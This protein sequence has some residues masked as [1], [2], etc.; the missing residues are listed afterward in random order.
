MAV[1]PRNYWAHVAL[2]FAA[3][4]TSINT[5]G[6][7]RAAKGVQSLGMNTTFSLEQVYQLGQLSLY[8]NIENFPDVEVT[9]EKVADGT[10]L[11]Q[12]LSTPAAIASSLAGRFNDNRSMMAVAFYPMTNDSASGIPLVYTQLSGMYVSAINWNM[13]LEGNVTESVTWVCRDKLNL[14]VTNV[15]PWASGTAGTGAAGRLPGYFTGSESPLTAS[16]GVQRRENIVMGSG[17][18]RWP[19]DIPG[20]DANGFN[21]SGANGFAAHIQNVTVSVNLGR[22]DLLELGRRGP[23]FRYANFPIEVSTSIDYVA[24]E[25]GDDKDV[26]ADQDNLVDH[27]IVIWLTDGTKIDLGSRNKLASSNA[28]GPDTAGGNMTV[29]RSY[30]NFNDYKALAHVSDPAGLT[31]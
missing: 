12:H 5:S 15:S 2:G 1:N 19:T 20:I 31:S 9:V 21:V 30:T 25:D 8:E 18:S 10:S 13:P 11:L 6:G 14:A 4:G 27:S 17:W 28:T 16:G 3:E 22:T 7:Y 23:Y 29:S 26:Y 24:N